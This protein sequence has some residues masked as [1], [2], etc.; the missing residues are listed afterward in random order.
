M[1]FATKGF[2]I[3]QDCFRNAKVKAQ[4]AGGNESSSEP[5]PRFNSPSWTRSIPARTA[6]PYSL[7][8]RPD[9]ESSLNMRTR[10]ASSASVMLLALRTVFNI[11]NRL[12][13]DT[14][15]AFTES[16][17]TAR[18]LS[19]HRPRADVYAFTPHES[20]Y[21]LMTLFGCITPLKSP[22]H[23]STDEMLTFAEEYMVEHGIVETGDTTVMVAGIPPNL[24][25]STNLMKVH[26]VGDV[27]G[28]APLH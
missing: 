22:P 26:R 20:T 18:L 8:S 19:K 2:V 27:T 15:V 16:G 12:G 24:R 14:I 25:A 5:R 1:I 23:E 13:I 28:G 6:S 3:T 7:L 10:S 17:T 9:G 4:K 21:R 11:S